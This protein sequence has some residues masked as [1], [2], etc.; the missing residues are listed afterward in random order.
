MKKTLWA[1]A[2]LCLFIALLWGLRPKDSSESVQPP[3]ELPSSTWSASSEDNGSGTS[4]ARH[5]G[6][7]GSREDSPSDRRFTPS[8]PRDF[9]IPGAAQEFSSSREGGSALLEDVESLL[10]DLPPGLYSEDIPDEYAGN[11]EDLFALLEEAREQNEIEEEDQPA[12]ALFFTSLQPDQTAGPLLVENLFAPQTGR[13]YAVFHSDT[14]HM[15]G[16][17]DILVRWFHPNGNTLWYEDVSILSGMPFNYIWY[18]NSFWDPGVYYVGLYGLDNDM[19]LLVAGSFTVEER[20]DHIGNLVVISDPSEIFRQT[21]FGIAEPVY[22]RFDYQVST[23]LELNLLIF[24][25]ETGEV[26]ISDIVSLP[27]GS[28][29]F[30]SLI[31]RDKPI[32]PP[33]S[34]DVEL[35]EDNQLLRGR[36]RFFLH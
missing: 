10:A 26:F 32:F 16:R 34:Y 1:A 24:K 33:G 31:K 17:D 8:G 20:F 15:M 5:T 7:F 18:E 22:L 30:L 27:L 21:D 23:P 36:V 19:G 35:W 25:I 14:Q 29:E 28:S 4:S 13:I 9:Q 2:A 3:A 12:D 11:L 6:T